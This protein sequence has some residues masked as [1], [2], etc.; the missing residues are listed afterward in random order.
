METKKI[1]FSIWLFFCLTAPLHAT[2]LNVATSEWL[3][4]VGQDLPNHGLAIDIVNTALQRAGYEPVV[5]IKNWSRTLEGANVGV[6]DLIAAAWYSNERARQ[7]TFSKPYLY[8]EIKI[9]KRADSNFEFNSLADL[10]GKSI[11]VVEDYAYG[12]AFAQ[13]QAEKVAVPYVL[14][15]IYKVLKGEVDLT[16]GDERVLGYEIEHNIDDGSELVIL[17]NPLTRKSLHIAVSKQNPRHE[18]IARAFDTAIDSM[19]AD[20][21]LARILKEHSGN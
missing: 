12:D 6:Y 10:Q 15:N 17:P 2:Q 4:Y 18:E 8:N 11:G 19:R 13:V 16:L 1:F 14:L 5:E 7:F 9:L 21:T 3:P 20:G